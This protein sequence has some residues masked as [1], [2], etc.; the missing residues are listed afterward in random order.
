MQRD[1]L[2]R[3]LHAPWILLSFL[4]VLAGCSSAGLKE[5][6]PER[7]V[8]HALEPAKSGV[9]A[10]MAAEIA[11]E[12]GQ[13]RSGFKIL[14][15][16]YDGLLWRLA[17]I[18]SAT[19]SLD[20]QTYLWYPDFSGRLILER[21]I[22]ASQRGVKVRLIVDDLILHGH[23][24][25]IA[26][27]HAAPNIDFGLFNPWE[28]RGTM[29]NRAG[30]MLAQMERLNTRMHDKLM[31][32]D[33][34]AVVVGG[35][36]IGD[37]Y[38][39][40]SDTY[41]FHDT[42]LLGVGHIAQQ[43]NGMFDMFWNS[44]WVVTADALTTE[45]DRDIAREQRKVLQD[46]AANAPVL[47]AFPR[48]PKDWTEDWRALAPELRIGRSKL[49]YDEAAA[50]QI[51]Q[52]MKNGMF[53]FFNL[54]QEEL[55][56]QNAYVIPQEEALTFIQSKTD[57][58]VRVRL[59]TNS[60]ASHDVPAV[61]SHYEPW[62]DD[63]V[64]VGVDLWEFRA[65]PEIQKSIIDV[66]PAKAEF[67]GLHSK[68]AVADRRYVFIGSMNLDPRSRNIN[69]E[70]GA[71]IDSPALAE[72]LVKILERNMSGANGWHVQMNSEG[73][74]TWQNDTETLDRQPARDT[75]QRVM[76]VLMKLG[77]RDQY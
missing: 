5:D 63:F 17:M 52:T 57:A 24:Q 12:H 32:V 43:A 65:H 41:N 28:N 49:V 21:A 73:D 1:S 11:R 18:D 4:I 27:L 66:A 47:A 29:A 74:L 23:D 59:M 58:G 69:T 37:H 48:S 22:L 72:D 30:E 56:I 54:A 19:T 2:P 13:D 20:I 25:L 51:T 42:D 36:N 64:R 60:L 53:N 75:T 33:G 76:N 14:D 34:H 7:M 39:G 61:N 26:N 10:D 31:I 55:L 44:E 70:M 16:S 50:E 67:S 40:L 71:M 45:P 3:V 9:L 35:R 46:S 62:R 77:P 6:R 8:S 68:C 15:S 38:F